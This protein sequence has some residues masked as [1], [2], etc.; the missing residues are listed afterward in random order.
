M[1]ASRVIVVAALAFH[2]AAASAQ[3]NV[4]ENAAKTVQVVQARAQNAALLKQYT[5]TERI[6]FQVN[7]T[8]KDLRLDLCNF[9]P[10]GKL[11]RTIMNDQS[12]PLPRGFFRRAIAKSK[13]EDM[14]K[15][16]KG[17]GQLFHQY[18]LPTP[19]AVLNFMDSA[20]TMPSGPNQLM[21]T[22]QN[23]VQPGD[24][25]TIYVNATTQ[26]TER[27]AVSTSYQGNPVTLTATF[28]TLP[29]GLNYPAYAEIEVPAKGYDILIQNFNYQMNG[30]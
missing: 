28:A 3:A 10:D 7:G 20:A 6:D 16:I 23:V 18:A 1:H 19:G 17:L 9:G 26:K 8:Q 12:A 25:L 27:V 5:W 11:Q 21:M 4:G 30:M 13:K 14:E 15:Y 2:A 24:S 29:N 22:G